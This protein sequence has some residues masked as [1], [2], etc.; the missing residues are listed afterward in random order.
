MDA[1]ALAETMGNVRP[2]TFLSH[3]REIRDAKEALHDASMVVARCKK[4]AK[5]DGI[6]L[7]VVSLLEKLGK[8]ESDEL[9]TH[10]R[11]LAVYGDW[12]KMPLA[13]FAE[14]ISAV[15]PEPKAKAR[16]E[17]QAWEAGQ[18]GLAA[19]RSGRARSD[20]PHEPGTEAHVAWDRSWTKGFRTSQKKIAG[21][22]V[23]QAKVRGAKAK[24]NGGGAQAAH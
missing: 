24:A 14:G 4:A 7:D 10:L 19:G 18:A 20:N 13:A 8:L 22:M 6:D 1:A 5:R 9:T 2:E 21:Q 11:K 23:D 15:V 16:D 3:W 12:L 17:F